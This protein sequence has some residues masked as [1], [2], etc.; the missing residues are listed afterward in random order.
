[1]RTLLCCLLLVVSTVVPAAENKAP[2]P[3]ETTPPNRHVTRELPLGYADLAQAED[4]LAQTLSPDGSYQLRK[5]KRTV[6]VT[7]TPETIEAVRA[8]LGVLTAQAGINIKIE[9]LH[10]TVGNSRTTGAGISGGGHVTNPP[11]AV[12]GRLPGQTPGVTRTGPGGHPV[13]GGSSG[14]FSI[15]RPGTGSIDINLLDQKTASDQLVKQFI[16]VRSGGTGVIEVVRE[17]PMV[18]YFLLYG[19]RSGFIAPEVHWEKAGAQL[20]VRPVLT[21][22]VITVEVIPR[23]SQVVF[24]DR[25]I[26]EHRPANT[27]LTGREQYVEYTQLSTTVTVANGGTITIGGFSSAPNEFNRYFFGASRTSGG[28]A[29]P[30]RRCFG[31]P[32]TPFHAPLIAPA[33]AP[34]V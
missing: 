27:P 33:T 2:G 26:F 18:D 13:R 14:G 21:G 5:I 17:V 30:S 29:E 8:M 1:M 31:M 22:D 32:F 11:Y 6:L 23:I 24:A 19:A 7:D 20:L 16:T 15:T 28:S 3:A 10:R 4:M 34:V 9:V 25:D 12:G